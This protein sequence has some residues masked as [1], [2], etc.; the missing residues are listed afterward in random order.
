[1]NKSQELLKLLDDLSS[2]GNMV[3]HFTT[4]THAISIISNNVLGK[5]TYNHPDWTASNPEGKILPGWFSVTRNKNYSGRS[6]DIGFILSVDK[7]KNKYKMTQYSDPF[8]ATD[9]T[10]DTL[11]GSKSGHVKRWESEE[12][13]FGPVSP[14]DKYLVGI[15]SNVD[16][17]KELNKLKYNLR[18]IKDDI[19]LRLDTINKP[20]FSDRKNKIIKD[21]ELDLKKPEEKLNPYLVSRINSIKKLIDW[22]NY[23]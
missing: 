12:L 3:Y 22:S 4:L 5:Y 20:P 10:G 11:T 13:I 14:L 17:N 8:V 15:I 6:K 7:L 2:S 23:D 21:L 19:R 16:L 9:V 1:M 18:H